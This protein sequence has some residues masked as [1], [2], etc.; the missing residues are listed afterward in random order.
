M[1]VS[2]VASGDATASPLYCG[3]AYTLSMT[4]KP[5]KSVPATPAAPVKSAPASHTPAAIFHLRL[6]AAHSNLFLGISPFALPLSH[7]DSCSRNAFALYMKMLSYRHRT[8]DHTNAYSNAKA[9]WN[10]YAEHFFCTD[11]C[12]PSGKYREVRNDKS[13]HIII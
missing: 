11:K 1:A 5:D 2:S 10:Q 13:Y 7:G 9:Q 3:A 6:I 8:P 4:L 12:Q